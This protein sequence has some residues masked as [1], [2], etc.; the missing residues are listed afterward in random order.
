MTFLRAGERRLLLA[1]ASNARR[2][3]RSPFLLP[4]IDLSGPNDNLFWIDR[5]KPE[6]QELQFDRMDRMGRMKAFGREWLTS[7]R[8][9][10]PRKF[11]SSCSYPVHPVHPVKLQFLV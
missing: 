4:A 7:Q 11:H 5:T 1:S 3:R 10:L 2:M 9:P 6:N 8:A